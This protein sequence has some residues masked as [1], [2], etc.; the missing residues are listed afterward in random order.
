MSK[1]GNV[2]CIKESLPRTK[3]THNKLKIIRLRGLE[4]TICLMACT[5]LILY[6]RRFA[7]KYLR[8]TNPA[9]Q[10]TTFTISE[11]V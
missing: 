1:L 6:M 5:F 10:K 7:H 2:K 3:P 11:V 9:L 8:G 4:V